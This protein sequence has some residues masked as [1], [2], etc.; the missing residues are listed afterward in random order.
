MEELLLEERTIGTKG[1]LNRLREKGFIPGIIYGGGRQNIPVYLL[2]KE[3]LSRFQKAKTPLFSLNIGGKKEIGIIK[4]KQ[5]DPVKNEVIHLDF[6]RV[7]LKEKIEIEISI[8]AIGIPQGVKEGGVLE[9]HI[10]QIN[11]KCPASSIPE[12][13]DV[14]VSGLN[15][16]D[17]LFVK[18]IIVSKDIE[19]LEDKEK[20]VFSIAPP[21]VVK[22]EEEVKEA[23]PAEPEVIKRGKREE[24]GEIE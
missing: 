5:I 14:D 23:L 21:R 15:I 2:K 8:R 22:E 4:E 16:N 12:A 13:I 19:I 20:I 3:F 18:D 24:E 6:M 10:H 9:Q 1:G 11:I 7:S 17:T